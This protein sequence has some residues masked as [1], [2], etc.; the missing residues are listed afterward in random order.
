MTIRTGAGPAGGLLASP[1]AAS[2]SARLT[3]LDRLV[4]AGITRSGPD[5]FSEKLLR[6]A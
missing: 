5:G 6:D 4:Q 1:P 3:A 2:L